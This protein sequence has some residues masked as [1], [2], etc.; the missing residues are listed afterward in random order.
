MCG[1]VASPSAS[2]E[3]PAIHLL[4]CSRPPQV[5][6]P[7]MLSAATHATSCSRSRSH[8]NNT[9]R[10]ESRARVPRHPSAIGLARLAPRPYES[11]SYHSR[12]GTRNAPQCSWLDAL[13]CAARAST[14][15]SA[16]RR[17]VCAA[18]CAIPRIAASHPSPC[19][20]VHSRP[21]LP[22]AFAAP[23]SSLTS[24]IRTLPPCSWRCAAGP[25]TWHGIHGRPPLPSAA[26]PSPP[27]I[28]P[29]RAH[30]SPHESL[31]PP[32]RYRGCG[33]RHIVELGAWTAASTCR[34]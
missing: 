25:D 2:L 17:T 5:P 7:A 26:R 33:L 13:T 20:P 22:P 24:R 6:R 3:C 14:H 28:C 4:P 27:I 11:H 21:D 18:A 29:T 1:E 31:I 32:A 19:P 34:S 12:L 16:S 15:F 23:S 8:N 9:L 10:C 30:P